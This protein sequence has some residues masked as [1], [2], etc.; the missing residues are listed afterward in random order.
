MYFFYFFSGTPMPNLK[1]FFALGNDSI[2]QPS[3]KLHFL[4]N[5]LLRRG[6][7]IQKFKLGHLFSFRN[8]NF[9]LPAASLAPF[10]SCRTKI[11]KYARTP[12]KETLKLNFS[13]NLQLSLDGSALGE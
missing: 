8:E 7:Q 5:S 9:R 6:T 3:V 11:A 2:L 1:R 10:S 12:D 4:I 13:Y